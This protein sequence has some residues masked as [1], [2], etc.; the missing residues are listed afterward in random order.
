MN[1]LDRALQQQRRALDQAFADYDPTAATQRLASRIVQESLTAA[2]LRSCPAPPPDSDKILTDPVTAQDRA[3]TELE[4]L[5]REVIG[6]PSTSRL[7]TAFVNERLPAGAVVFSCLLY[8]TGRAE[9]A[10]FWWKFA[11]GADEDEAVH[12]LVLHHR[13]ADEPRDEKRW[14][15]HIR[16]DVSPASPAQAPNA[17]TTDRSATDPETYVTYA[18]SGIREVEDPDFGEVCI[19]RTWLPGRMMLAGRI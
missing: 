7:L 2:L 14:A 11:A 3:A 12:F 18:E 19:P 1:A 13:V 17:N 9:P 8:L 5:C 4:Q 6:R 10:A 16:N 15:S